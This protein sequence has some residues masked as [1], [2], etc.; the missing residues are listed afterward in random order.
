M[1]VEA[2]IERTDNRFPVAQAANGTAGVQ[3]KG[4]DGTIVAVLLPYDPTTA[5]AQK[6]AD[7]LDRHV[8]VLITQS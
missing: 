8:R 6:I 5:E 2:R 1:E 7:F 4:P 3:L